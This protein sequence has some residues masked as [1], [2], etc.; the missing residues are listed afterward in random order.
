[1]NELDI[2]YRALLE[3]DR[4]TDGVTSCETFNSTFARTN[5]EGDRVKVF[6]SFCTVDEDW[7]TAIEEGLV[8]VEKALKEE[9]QFIASNGEVVPIEK[10]KGV[11]KES[12]QH[13]ARHSNLITRVPEEG[14]DMVPDKLF[15]VERLND[16]AVYE[17]RFLYMLLCYLRDFIT[18][19][20]NKILDLTNKYEGELMV[21][22]QV[23]IPKRTLDYSVTLSEVRKDDRYLSENNPIRPIVDRID[24]LLKAVLAFL[25]TP[26]MECCSKV[27]MI[28]PPITKTNV[29]KS[30]NNFKGAL[31][32]YE[33]IVAYDK[34]G[35]TVETKETLISPFREDMAKDF[36]GASALIS[37]IAYQYGLG[38]KQDLKERYAEQE[39]ARKEEEL[40]Q[41]TE[42]LLSLGR[43]LKA[44]GISPEEYA[45]RL[46]KQLR[47]V[48]LEMAKLIALRKIVA[49]QSERIEKLT[50]DLEYSEQLRAEQKAKYEAELKEQKEYYEAAL[51]EQ[52][53]S[54][55]RIIAEQKESYERALAEQKE[56]YEH[57]LAE[58]K[59]SYERALAEQKE[60]YECAIA[61]QAE[62]Y[63]ARLASQADSYEQKLREQAE[64]YE[65]RLDEQKTRYEAEAERTEKLHAD[66]ICAIRAEHE[67]Q[68][69]SVK[70]GYESRIAAI[71][72]ASAKSQE[73]LKA[74][75]ERIRSSFAVSISEKDS[76]L[77]ELTGAYEAKNAEVAELVYKLQSAEARIKGMRAQRGESQGDF[78]DKDSFDALEREYIAFTKFYNQECAKAKKQI[79]KNI[80]NL[81]NLKDKNGSDQNRN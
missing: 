60:S 64:D 63:E 68:L 78:T 9:R 7:V 15:T 23:I 31:R 53:E 50:A 70:S 74:E 6:R 49:E 45:L 41:L 56:S 52:K 5:L 48:D 58:Q 75:T 3:L 80:L 76:R 37:F 12:V 10:V 14:N 77:S 38:I 22:K 69:G 40:R 54:Y 32:L 8:H 11:S 66:R 20:Y 81:K 61:K 62:D 4:L 18:I 72:E 17:N 39:K 46:E 43:K 27:A 35:Y 44:S 19:R 79:R 42:Q 26:L 13:L 47:A 33:F 34:P 24:L 30:N 1:M 71:N 36:A 59:E 51:A 65:G 67:E 2:Y 29:L 25:S 73:T 57:A 21:N 55:E 28:K 16:Y